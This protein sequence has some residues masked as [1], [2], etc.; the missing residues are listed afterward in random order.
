MMI[1]DPDQYALIM[2]NAC[3]LSALPQ[4]LELADDW[5]ILNFA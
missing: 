2:G 5:A 3:R 1:A 4:V